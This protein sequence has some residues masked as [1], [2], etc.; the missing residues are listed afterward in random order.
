MIREG[1]RLGVVAA[2]VAWLVG[3]L[4]D[5]AFVFVAGLVPAV[6]WSTRAWEADEVEVWSAL[7]VAVIAAVVVAVVRWD[8]W[9]IPAMWLGTQLARIR[10]VPSRVD[11]DDAEVWA[12]RN[13]HRYRAGRP[14][15]PPDLSSSDPVVQITGAG[16]RKP[17]LPD[18]YDTVPDEHHVFLDRGSR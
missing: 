11:T 16:R 18:P 1:L 13:A 7:G 4:P 10:L 14:V 12:R 2:L 6:W 3:S 5:P 9:L 15:P 17:P 8:P